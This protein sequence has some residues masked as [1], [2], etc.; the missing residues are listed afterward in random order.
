MNWQD[1][2]QT[3]AGA[4]FTFLAGLVGVGVGIRQ[5]RIQMRYDFIEK[6]LTNLYSPLLGIRNDIKA[7]TGLR[8]QLSNVAQEAW[9]EI[10]E[11]KKGILDWDHDKEFKPFSNMIEYDNKQFHTEL[12]PQ[13]REML[14]IMKENSWLAETETRKWYAELASF[15]E[16][17]NRWL[18]Q[19]LPISVLE[20]INHSE[21][22]LNGFYKHIED[23]VER[24]RDQLPKR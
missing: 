11:R 21:T 22:K 5:V 18:E 16:I 15:I 8:Y 23:T 2:L 24:L 9:R 7:K 19:S 12:L 13:Y 10:C 3:G 6:Q 4:L 14:K 1:V 20:K 17:W